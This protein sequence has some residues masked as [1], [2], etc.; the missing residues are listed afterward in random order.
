MDRDLK[1]NII[2][3]NYQYPNKKETNDSSYL[4]INSRNASCIDNLDIYLKFN[5]DEILEDAFFLKEKH[6]L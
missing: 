3:E 2:L 4:K 5:K 1:R 6:V